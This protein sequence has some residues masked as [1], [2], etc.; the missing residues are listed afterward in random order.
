MIKYYIINERRVILNLPQVTAKIGQPLNVL[1]ALNSSIKTK[2]K[3]DDNLYNVFMTFDL[4]KD[5]IRFDNPM[6]YKR[7]DISTY[8]YFGN[9]SA[10]AMQYYLVREA[11]NLRYLL[12][13]TI[14]DLYLELMKNHMEDSYILSLIEELATLDHVSLSKKKGKGNVNL[15]KLSI[16]EKEDDIALKNK[17]LIINDKKIKF[18][19][20]IQKSLSDNNKKNKYLLVIPRVLLK[21]GKEIILSKLDDYIYLVKLKNKLI[22]ISSDNKT[23]KKYCYICGNM[24]T[25]VRCSEYM[26][27][28]N[29]DG[30]NKIFTTTTINSSRNITKKNYKDNYA[31]CGECYQ[32]LRAGEKYIKDNLTTNIAGERTFL[33]PEGLMGE[34]DYQQLESIKKEVDLFFNPKTAKKWIDQLEDEAKITGQAVYNLNFI[35]YRTDGNSVDILQVIQDVPRF[36]LYKI[37]QLFDK[38]LE[39]LDGY[40][41]YMSLGTI[42]TIVPVKT[43]KSGDQLDIVRILSL[44]ETMLN[45]GKVNNG[46][47]FAYAIEAIEKGLKEI[48]K[49]KN[50]SSNISFKNLNPY[51]YVG[52]EDFYISDIVMKYIILIHV[53]QGINVLSKNEFI[54]NKGG[55]V[56][57]KSEKIV[58]IEEFLD[59]QGFSKEA[60]GLFYLGT[61]INRVSYEQYKKDHKNKPILKKIQFQGMNRR[62]VVR[63]Y[64]DTV[65]KLRQYDALTLDIEKL[66]AQ[67]HNYFGSLEKNWSLD[68]KANVFYIMA[69]YSYMVKNISFK[70]NK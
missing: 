57:V 18:E 11:S 64:E 5:E 45:K 52:K 47:V 21:S 38:E 22:N 65:E 14:S 48:Q 66:I 63:L 4:E 42:Y 44:Y 8:G 58:D 31:L 43:N 33:I 28:L 53:L 59:T 54:E 1:N 12:G 3:K 15:K 55:E 34:F 41:D 20:V 70:E 27:E 6:A 19:Q 24:K 23:T 60:R 61:L 29:R 51:K 46:V 68:D 30:I 13:S 26:K 35:I 69:G 36:Y 67:F 7:D 39:K 37:Q 50:G 25:D 9:N 17:E 2:V 56:L 16:I 49:L 10:A 32:N 62:D 40:L